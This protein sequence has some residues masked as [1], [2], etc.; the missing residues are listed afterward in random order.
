MKL[1]IG[2]GLAAALVED[3]SRKVCKHSHSLV[4]KRKYLAALYIQVNFC[5][6]A[7]GNAENSVSA[8]AY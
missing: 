8:F 3:V 7:G 6:S 5:A 4:S 2:V 1:G